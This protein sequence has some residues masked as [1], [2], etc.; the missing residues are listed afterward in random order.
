MH[1][2]GVQHVRSYGN[3]TSTID[4]EVI[5]RRQLP[6][7]KKNRKRSEGGRKNAKKGETRKRWRNKQQ[8]RR[9]RKRKSVRRIGSV[10]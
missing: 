8:M 4:W 5:V 3:K 2:S 1:P 10:Q 7:P 6:R 9:L